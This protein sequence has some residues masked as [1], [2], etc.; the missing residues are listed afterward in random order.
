MAPSDFDSRQHK[1]TFSGW[2]GFPRVDDPLN[3]HIWR[4][5]PKINKSKIFGRINTQAMLTQII[6]L[7]E[8]SDQGLFC[9]QFWIFP[10]YDSLN[11][12]LHQISLVLKFI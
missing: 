9:L 1:L 7:L 12:I 2:N 6:L 11:R 4:L 3:P 8:E 10:S 5:D